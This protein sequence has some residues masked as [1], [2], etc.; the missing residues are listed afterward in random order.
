[1]Q[2]FIKDA[3]KATQTVLAVE[4][5]RSVNPGAASEVCSLP[6]PEA[7]R[8]QMVPVI[9]QELGN[10]STSHGRCTEARGSLKIYK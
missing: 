3:H 2:L 7:R 1:M 8:L 4:R 6:G 9:P 5:R 10:T